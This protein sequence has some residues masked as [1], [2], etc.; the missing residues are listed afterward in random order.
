MF[1][2]VLWKGISS[3]VNKWRRE[4][5]GLPRTNLYRLAQYDIPFLYN[6][7]PTIFPP[8]VDFPDWVKVTGY[9]FLDEGAADDFEPLKELV[10]FMN[11]ARADIRRL[12]TLGLVLSWWKMP[13]AL[14][15]Q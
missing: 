3:Q 10:E 11:K 8:S 5:L 9:W 15:R 6:I 1:E 2:T 7:S 13:R 14:Q 12:F 4:L